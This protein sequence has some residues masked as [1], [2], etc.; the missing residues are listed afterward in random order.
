MSTLRLLMDKQE[1]KDRIEKE[2]N[3]KK[4]KQSE[5]ENAME[6]LEQ[7]GYVT[8]SLWHISDV[9][10]RWKCNDDD[11]LINQIV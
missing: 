3:M 6:I 5:I 1:I 10:D 11:W 4:K 7:A 9:Q 2:E 8:S